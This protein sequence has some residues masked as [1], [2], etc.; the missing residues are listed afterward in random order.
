MQRKGPAT[1]NDFLYP[2]PQRNISKVKD[3]STGNNLSTHVFQTKKGD[4]LMF[5]SDIIYH[6]VMPNQREED[7]IKY[8]NELAIMLILIYNK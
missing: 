2:F 6:Y 8:I 5:P 7:R 1:A 3:D 4:I